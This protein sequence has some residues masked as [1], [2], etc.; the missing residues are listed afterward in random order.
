VLLYWGIFTLGFLFGAILSFVTLAPKKPEE[1]PEYES[2]PINLINDSLPIVKN[3]IR[4]QNL[5]DQEGL[6]ALIVPKPKPK[7]S[8]AFAERAKIS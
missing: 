5:K 1:D 6:F 7:K 8:W 3:Q 2:Q 4:V